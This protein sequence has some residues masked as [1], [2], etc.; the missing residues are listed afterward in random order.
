MTNI[1][2]Q[3]YKEAADPLLC[4]AKNHS[5]A[6]QKTK[7][8]K[9]NVSKISAIAP[10]L[11]ERDIVTLR[12]EDSEEFTELAGEFE[13]DNDVELVIRKDE[14]VIFVDIPTEYSADFIV[15]MTE[16]DIKE[17]EDFQ[18]EKEEKDALNVDAKTTEKVSDIEKKDVPVHPSAKP[19]CSVDKIIDDAR[20]KRSKRALAIDKLRT[21]KRVGDKENALDLLGWLKN[22]G[23]S[24]LQG[25]D[26]AE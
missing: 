17:K 24:D 13:E 16:N 23:K 10:V 2:T 5:A 11:N 21:A 8:N 9:E 18:E 20:S 12:Y 4:K 15:F 7:F 25:V 22:P 26:D 6:A 3:G 19:E 14:D 1:K